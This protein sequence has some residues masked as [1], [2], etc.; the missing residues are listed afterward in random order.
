M[1][2]IDSH[3]HLDDIQYTQDLEQVVQRA[4]EKNVRYIISI[5][6]D[7]PS[8]HKTFAL[9][10]KY[11][12]IFASIGVHPHEAKSATNNTY[13]ILQKISEEATK[14]VAIGEIG[15]D[16]HYDHSPRETQKVVFRNL[17]S[18]AEDKKLPVVIHCR[19]AEVDTLS[20]LEEFRNQVIGVMHCFSGNVDMMKKCLDL[21]YFIS[22]AGPVTFKKATELHSIVKE[23]PSDRLLIETDCPYLT[24]VPFRGKRNEPAY[25]FHVAEKVAELRHVTLDE[26]SH[27]IIQN[28][29]QLFRLP[30]P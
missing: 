21:G 14:V 18:I 16:Y 25:V 3:A 8:C 6:Q 10:N 4:N 28:T 26:L 23:I 2:L 27:Q 17:M 20:I 9:A 22:I 1:Y 19:E 11:K 15:L 24:P 7:E 12:G 13:D 29:K 30:I 5:A